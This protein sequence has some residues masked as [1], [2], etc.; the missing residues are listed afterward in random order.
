MQLKQPPWMRYHRQL[1]IQ[2]NSTQ[3][4]QLQQ[5]PWK[6]S[7]RQGCSLHNLGPAYSMM[8]LHI[9]ALWFCLSYESH[10]LFRRLGHE[11]KCIKR[12]I[13][14]HSRNL[15][16]NH[17]NH[18]EHSTTQA[19]N[20]GDSLFYKGNLGQALVEDLQRQGIHKRYMFRS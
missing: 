2:L 4:M 13:F 19:E 15:K 6:V 14:T 17:W 20:D 16:K 1:I 7:Q 18:W 5:L 3:L 8:Q 12:P 10:E 9:C 11:E